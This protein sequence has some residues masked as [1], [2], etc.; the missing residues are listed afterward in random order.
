M[1]GWEVDDDDDEDN[2]LF[3]W[4]KNFGNAGQEDLLLKE[5][6]S[7]SASSYNPVSLIFPNTNYPTIVKFGYSDSTNI[8]MFT[9]DGNDVNGATW[10]AT[11]A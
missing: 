5:I 1:V 2:K 8:V 6:A 7:T 3:L 11:N 4:R 10:T 9:F